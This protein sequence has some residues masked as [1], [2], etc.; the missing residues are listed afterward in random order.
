MVEEKAS[1]IEVVHEGAEWSVRENG[2][3]LIR[4]FGRRAAVD[5]GCTLAKAHAPSEIVIRRRDGSVECAELFRAQTR[6]RRCR[7]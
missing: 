4:F 2:R 1:R 7:C 5:L 6:P 3:T